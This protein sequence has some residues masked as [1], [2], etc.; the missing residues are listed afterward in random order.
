MSDLSTEKTEDFVS[1]KSKKILTVKEFDNLKITYYKTKINFVTI[2]YNQTR[3]IIQLP[4]SMYE[5][6]QYED[7]YSI[8]III[9]SE[10]IITLLTTLDQINNKYVN[11]NKLTEYVNILQAMNKLKI[12]IKLD[13]L[14]IFDLTGK[15]INFDTF[16][17]LKNCGITPIVECTGLFSAQK[18]YCTWNILSMKV[19][20][21]DKILPSTK[22]T[23]DDFTFDDD[24]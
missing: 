15:E 6:T 16:K 14:S 9:S 22:L 11:D 24:D 17:N 3:F 13:I 1:V 8:G 7:K 2:Y 18:T 12:K 21:S 19:C 5:I 20:S 4:K 10:E 23:V